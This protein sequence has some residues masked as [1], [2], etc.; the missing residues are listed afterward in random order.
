MILYGVEI[1]DEKLIEA[2]WTPPAKKEAKNRWRGNENNTY[3]YINLHGNITYTCESGCLEDE[4]R[5]LLGNYFRTKEDAKKARDK[6]LAYMRLQDALLE[7]NDGWEPDWDDEHVKK[8]YVYWDME[9]IRFAL[10]ERRVCNYA[11]G[12]VGT[13]EACERL[14][15]EHEDDLRAVWGLE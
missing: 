14:I 1:P 12:L 15:A 13:R 2:G 8:Y 11:F 3:F 5:Y 6:Q 10:I 4:A 9:S 7:Y